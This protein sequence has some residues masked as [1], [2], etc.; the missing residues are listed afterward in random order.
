MEVVNIIIVNPPALKKVEPYYDE[1][2]YPRTALAFLAGYLRERVEL[3]DSV[4]VLDAK[5]DKLS[6]QK[7]IEE[8]LKVNPNVVG[9]TAMTNEIKS[10]A[11]VAK[12]IKEKDSSIVTVIGGVHVTAL[13]EET[14]REFPEFD[15]GI[16]GEGEGTFLNLINSLKQGSEIHINGVCYLDKKNKS[17]FHSFGQSKPVEQQDSISP[18]W[19]LFKPAKEYMLQSARGCPFTCNFCM[20]PGGRVVRSRSVK[21]TLDEIQY[22]V[23]TM[24]PESI[25]FGDEIFTINKKRA[26]E[27]CDGLIERGLHKKMTWWCQTHVNTLDDELAARM[28]ESG[29]RLVG[30]GIETGDDNIFKQMGKGINTKKVKQT[31]ELLKRHKLGYDTM[32]ILGQP[33]ET[34]ESAMKTINFAVELN[35][36]TPI[37]GLM[38]PYPGTA[39]GKMA[40]EGKGGYRL[41]SKDW[42]S[43]NKQIGNALELE[44]VSRKELERLQI[45]GYIKVFLYNWRI[46][47]FIQF[48]LRY[49]KEGFST[50]KK[51]AFSR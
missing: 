34:K 49:R 7:T 16:L 37:F 35:P 38:V 50:L 43:F 23:E 28:K 29:C 27:I 14:M 22:L 12:A 36:D 15:Y 41:I 3:T 8:I 47:D 9:L 42:D 10:A 39:V 24:K 48:C 25:Y 40:L 51:I 32:F 18:A 30:L 46:F 31:I 11:L 17:H 21:I 4:K 6:F 2:D 45:W 13:P 44:G 1:P 26:M 20:N 19:D 5:F 33:N